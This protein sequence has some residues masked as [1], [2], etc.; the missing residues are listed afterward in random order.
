MAHVDKNI[1]AGRDKLPRHVYGKLWNVEDSINQY[2]H[3]VGINA[4]S[5]RIETDKQKLIK[6]LQTALK[7]LQGDS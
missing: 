4:D 6:A 5:Q 2:Y 7:Q 1:K 3:V